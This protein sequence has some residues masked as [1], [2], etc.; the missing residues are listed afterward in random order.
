MNNNNIN[1]AASNNGDKGE[2]EIQK[3][4]DEKLKEH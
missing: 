4:I 1:G 2:D 3:Q